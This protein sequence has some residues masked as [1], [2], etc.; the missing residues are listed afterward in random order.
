MLGILNSVGRSIYFKLVL[1][2]VATAVIMAMSVGGIV[3]YVAD[4]RPYRGFVGKNM[5][6]YSMYIIDEIGTPPKHYK[7]TTD[8]GQIQDIHSDQISGSDL[9]VLDATAKQRSR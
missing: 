2:F 1:I 3:R 7:S 6:Q 9:V 8:S 5:A 4:E